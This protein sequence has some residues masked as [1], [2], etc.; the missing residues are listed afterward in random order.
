MSMIFSGEPLLVEGPVEGF[1]SRIFFENSQR[2][3]NSSDVLQI[4]AIFVDLE[5]LAF[6]VHRSESR[7]LNSQ[8]VD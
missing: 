2:T 3:V 6:G 7:W 4:F 5:R 8:K 1:S